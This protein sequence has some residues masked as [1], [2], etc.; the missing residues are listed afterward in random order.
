MSESTKEELK[1]EVKEVYFVFNEQYVVI[2]KVD[3]VYQT[4][5][6]D[7]DDESFVSVV[8][9]V[10]GRA[11]KEHYSCGQTYPPDKKKI[12]GAKS[13]ASTRVKKI[14]SYLKTRTQAK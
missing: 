12:N 8:L 4:S 14:L 13:A 7:C 6:W 1:E 2:D 11:L 9:Y 3:S 5:V 10:N